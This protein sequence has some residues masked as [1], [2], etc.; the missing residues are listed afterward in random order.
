[1]SKK[2][3]YSGGSTVIGPGSSW[4]GGLKGIAKQKRERALQ[5]RLKKEARARLKESPIAGAKKSGR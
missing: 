4:F 1:M 5:K 2:G 3:S